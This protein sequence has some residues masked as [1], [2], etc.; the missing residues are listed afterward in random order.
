ML[1]VNDK[2]PLFALKNSTDDLVESKKLAGSYWV[3]YF[4]P[5]DDTSGCTLEA[6]GFS[7]QKKEFDALGVTIIG[8]SKD[9]VSSHASFCAKYALD[10]TLVSDPDLVLQKACGVWVEKSM[11]GRTY[12]GTQRATFLIDP[13]GNIVQAWP[14]VKVKGHVDDVLDTCRRL[15]N[16]S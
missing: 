8:V 11:Y 13:T 10:I 6:Q 3:L 2:V 16:V 15:I 12:M 5:K 9:S 14:K 4:Y 7:A 1:A